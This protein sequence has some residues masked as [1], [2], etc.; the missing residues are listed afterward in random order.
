MT[1][2]ALFASSGLL[3]I[4]AAAPAAAQDQDWS[5]FYVG[6]NAGASWGDTALD[7]KVQG[8]NGPVALP[9]ADV[10]I[11]NQV[12]AEDGNKTAF[13]GGVQGGYNYQT[14]NW[15]L[16]L[17]TD[18]GFFDLDQK[19]TNAYRSGVLTNPQV[20]Y[21]LDQRVK[22]D[23]IWT[24]RPRV[25]YAW[26][27]WMGYVTGGLATTETK[28][29]TTL[30]DNRLPQNVAAFEKSDTDTGWTGGLGAAY[31]FNTHI[32][33]HGDWLYVDF[34]KVHGSATTPND[35][36]IIA[37]EAKVRA[38]LLRIGVDYRF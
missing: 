30:Q 17:E 5:G 33:L 25:G 3:V 27:P 23:W 36:A 21:A 26:G 34:G 4:A 18:F 37:P 31:R 6:A 24:L 38:N 10:G 12:G 29:T 20:T 2:L 35:F 19:R 16:G 14:G 15:V 8:P 7:L 22:T 9:P 32:A 11:I 1:R 13:T 28:F